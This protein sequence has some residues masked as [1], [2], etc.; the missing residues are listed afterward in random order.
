MKWLS[1]VSPSRF[2]GLQPED[3]NGHS[4]GNVKWTKDTGFNLLAKVFGDVLTHSTSKALGFPLQLPGRVPEYASNREIEPLGKSGLVLSA[5]SPTSGSG[6]YTPKR[7]VR[8]S[9][10]PYHAN[11][12]QMFIE[13][14][15]PGATEDR[16]SRDPSDANFKKYGFPVGPNHLGITIGFSAILHSGDF[17]F[18]SPNESEKWTMVSSAMDGDKSDFDTVCDDF[19]SLGEVVQKVA[20]AMNPEAPP[21]LDGRVA[22]VRLR[23]TDQPLEAENWDESEIVSRVEQLASIVAPNLSKTTFT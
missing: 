3:P 10:L 14:Y 20:D 5:N 15:M 18:S 1:S 12:C 11:S 9:P 4:K 21:I 23:L 2:I 17:E 16:N 19:D 8:L 22:R 7:Y 13:S 6:V